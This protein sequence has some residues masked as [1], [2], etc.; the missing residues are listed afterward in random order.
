MRHFLRFITLLL[1][2]TIVLSGNAWGA[3][4]KNKKLRPVPA[5]IE[6]SRRNKDLLF[7]SPKYDRY[8]KVYYLYYLSNVYSNADFTK[9]TEHL[10]ELHKKMHCTG[11]ELIVYVD[12]TEEDAALYQKNRRYGYM[13]NIPK[14]C[15]QL[16]AKCP[17]VNV[18]RKEVRD[19]LFKEHK[20]PFGSEYSYSYPH[21]RAIDADGNALAYFM[22]SDHSV[23]MTSPTRRTPQLVVRGVR[24]ES[25]WIVDT[26][27]ATHS[28][29]VKQAESLE[30][31]R[32]EQEDDEDADVKKKKKAA[33]K[34]KDASKKKSTGKQFKRPQKWRKHVEEEDEDDDDEEED[35]DDEYEDDEEDDEYEDDYWDE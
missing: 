1:L 8:A 3:P 2:A 35:E 25:E 28:T 30:A 34:K 31:S 16:N 4:K 10:A 18:Y 22:L 27:L 26:I 14:R 33:G 11:A 5:L 13:A 32:Q 29:L 15:R 23:R 19:K 17:F 21:L 20:S 9:A 24:K 12:Y 7:N 6:S